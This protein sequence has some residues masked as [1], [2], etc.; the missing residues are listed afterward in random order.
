MHAQD[1]DSTM[2]RQSCEWLGEVSLRLNVVIEVLDG[3]RAVSCPVGTT[4]DA[5]AL[6]R[7]I[8]TGEPVLLDAIADASHSKTPV[9]VAV[10]GLQALCF[11]LAPGGSLVLARRL[12]VR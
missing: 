9:P 12:A 3:Q 10:D 11:G 8:S 2:S 1:S 5:A 6:R 7:I 4:L